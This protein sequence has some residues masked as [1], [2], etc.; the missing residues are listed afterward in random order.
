[1]NDEV[2]RGVTEYHRSEVTTQKWHTA[3]EAVL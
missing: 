3:H 2:I 1:M